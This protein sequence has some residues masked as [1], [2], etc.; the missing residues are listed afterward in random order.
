MFDTNTLSSHPLVCSYFAKNDSKQWLNF[1]SNY[2][3]DWVTPTNS[4]PGLW[5]K[6]PNLYFKFINDIIVEISKQ[7]RFEM[8]DIKR[9]SCNYALLTSTPSSLLPF[10]TIPHFDSKIN[11]QMAIVH[12]LCGQE[13][14]GTGFFRHNQSGIELIDSKNRANYLDTLSVEIQ[15]TANVSQSYI[16][17][18]H[19]LFTRTHYESAEFGKLVTYPGNLLHSACVPES[20]PVVKHL[21]DGRLTITTFIELSHEFIF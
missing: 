18:N 13:F 19:P 20:L 3:P 5:A 15:D 8:T 16:S 2:R 1:A 10:Q 11:N 4:Y 9:V 6:V 21:R 7:H 17:D 14:G 12:Y